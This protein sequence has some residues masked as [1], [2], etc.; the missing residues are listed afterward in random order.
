M[1]RT[2]VLISLIFAGLGEA[3]PQGQDQDD[4][5]L[6]KA[7]KLLEEAKAAYESARE[8]NSTESF[9]DAGFKLEEARIKYFVLQEIGSPEKQ[10]IALDRLRAINQL[11]KLIHDGKVAVTGKPAEA[12]APKPGDPPAPEPAPKPDPATPAPV[13]VDVAKRAPVPEA[14]KQRE[15]EKLLKDLFKDQ[16]GKKAPADKAILAKALLDQARKSKDDPVSVWVTCHEAQ[17]LATQV[18]DVKTL[19]AAIEEAARVF[20]VDALAMKTS[21]LAAAGKTARTPED[22]SALAVA[23][24]KLIDD[25]MA[26]DQYDAAEKAAASASQ[27]ARRA[28]DA[29]LTAR[30]AAR[31]KDVAEAKSRF[32]S[33]K[34]VLQTLARTPEDPAANLEM[35]QFLCFVKSNWDLGPRFLVRG[36]DAAL[37]A[38]AEKELALAANPADQ[39]AVADG[40][41][42][43]AEK[44]KV[45]FRKNQLLAH[46][47]VL[48]EGAIDS[49]VGLARARIEKRLEL[50]GNVLGAVPGER[51]AVNLLRLIDLAQDR[52]EG[53]WTLEG[54]VLLCAKKAPWTR[55]QVPYIPPDE[56]DLTLV[57]ERKESGGSLH[58]GVAKG[59]VQFFISFEG[60]NGTG[61]E[62]L[63]G[64]MAKDNE[65]SFKGPALA[66]SGPSTIICSLRKEGVTVTVDGKKIVDW[67]GNYSR[68]GT[69]PEFKIPNA[70][71]LCIGA[72]GAA[73]AFTKVALTPVTG[74][75]KR[76]R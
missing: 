8:K 65:T 56:Y 25:L 68:L 9:V 43:L 58:I 74:D 61:L 22:L 27:H 13:P 54:G 33:L 17:D 20:D 32:Q 36:S 21:A 75:G 34:T 10:K 64:R 48:Y 6:E 38:L 28:N 24:D 66:G 7:D 53:D 70:R 60:G 63:D 49:A 40:W 62:V 30:A 12:P 14:A 41:Y 1:I 52:V 18:C 4:R 69:I 3:A 59:T 23:L 29:K 76:I 67:K 35:G 16:Y 15:A 55:V 5:I 11:S 39:M 45:P 37:K 2:A 71:A 31:V 47:R 57:V 51:P 26:A 19:M 44:E 50:I 46:A 42:D 72:Y 73:C